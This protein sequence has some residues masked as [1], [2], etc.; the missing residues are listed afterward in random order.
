MIRLQLQ[1]QKGPVK[2]NAMIDSGA[3][4]DFI[5]Q[6]LCHKYGIRTTRNGSPRTIYLADGKRSDMGPVTHVAKVPM[7]IGS[8]HEQ[9][10]FQVANLNNHEAVLGMPW[11]REHSPTI[12]WANHKVTFN[13]ERCTMGCLK[14]PP[15]V[16]TIPEG[17][18]ME[19]NLHMQ[20]AHM[21]CTKNQ[22]IRVK[23]LK[24]EARL[25]SKGSAKAAGHDLFAQ[26]EARI[27]AHGQKTVGTG[28]AIGLP[29]GTY[30][31]IAPR[32]GLAVKHR[33]HVMAG[34]IDADYTG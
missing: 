20:H 9:A 17:E 34:V 19:E 7:K 10:T 1:G 32:S 5:D 13:S 18:A 3:T 21:Q 31:R 15:M 28:I 30:G 24:V 4:E 14:E 33:L 26:E 22:M 23:K 12:D 29:D 11:L 16:Y 2:V 8:H 6:G 25:P 27:P